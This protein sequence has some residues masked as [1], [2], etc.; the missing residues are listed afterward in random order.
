MRTEI[1]PFLLV[2]RESGGLP[3]PYCSRAALIVAHVNNVLQEPI[4][5]L[6]SDEADPRIHTIADYFAQKYGEP[7]IPTPLLYLNGM[8]VIGVTTIL[9]YMGVMKG[10]LTHD[11]KYR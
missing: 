9:N 4:D 3:C 7:A 5:I 8:I 11:A 2:A 6:C 1:R 10:L